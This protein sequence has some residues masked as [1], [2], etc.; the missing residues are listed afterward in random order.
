[1]KHGKNTESSWPRK[2]G[3]RQGHNVE[4]DNMGTIER[5]KRELAYNAWANQ[6]ALRSL[7][8]A[9]TKPER[10]GAVTAHIIAAEWLWLR[11]LGHPSPAM[12]VWPTFSLGECAKLL[13]DLGQA[14]Q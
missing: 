6:E 5:L 7:L 3:T 8:V 2:R 14:L 12:D 11:R 10:A 13:R 9:R 1:M 4:A